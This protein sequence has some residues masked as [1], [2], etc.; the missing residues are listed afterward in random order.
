MQLE[1]CLENARK[2]S[3]NKVKREQISF[4]NVLIRYILKGLVFFLDSLY[5]FRIIKIAQIRD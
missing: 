1:I 4:R 5:N 3:F 2:A